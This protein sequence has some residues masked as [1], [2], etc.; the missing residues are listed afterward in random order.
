MNGYIFNLSL[1]IF[2]V[3]ISKDCNYKY[4]SA[5]QTT[6]MTTGTSTIFQQESVDQLNLLSKTFQR[7]A[8]EMESG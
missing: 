2:G 5:A 4:V 8:T 7:A 3:H 1:E 6:R